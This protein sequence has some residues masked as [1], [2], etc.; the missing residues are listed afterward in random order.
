[1][2]DAKRTFLVAAENGTFPGGKVGGVGDVLRDLPVALAGQGWRPTVL[3]PGYGIFG[4]LPGATPERSVS[5]SFG[6]GTQT[7]AV[8]R[9]PGPDERVQHI[10]FEHPFFSPQGPGRIYCADSDDRPFATDASKF[11]FL[12]AAAAAYIGSL[13]RLPDVVHLHDWHAALYCVLR[14]ND[15]RC[16]ALRSVRTVFTIHNL[17]MQGIRPLDGDASSLRAWLPD[18]DVDRTGVV[19]PRYADCINP[20]AAAIRL[21][22]KLNT[23]SPT[24]AAEILRP[25]APEHGFHGGE[26]LETDLQRA[27]AE[28]RLIGILNGCMYPR[29][30]RRRPG[31]RRL[32]DTIGAEVEGW[33]ERAPADRVFHDAALQRLASLPKRRP[34]TVLTSVGRLTPQKAELFLAGSDKGRNALESILADLGRSGILIMLGSGDRRLQTRMAEIASHYPNFLFLCGYSEAFTDLLYEAGD[35]FLMPSSFEPCGISQMLAMRAGQPCVVHAVGGLRDT[36]WHEVNGF[37][38]EGDTLEAQARNFAATVRRALETKARDPDRWLHIR[39]KAAAAR[40]TWSDAA[41]NYASELY[42]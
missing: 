24:Y 7:V 23:V 39:D 3:T 31:W 2:S 14:A 21:A 26:G 20:M 12:S 15:P 36:V 37:T 10:A 8:L 1:V 29:R 11:A 18:L 33:R 40:F 35:L 41:A 13:D 42:E 6:G 25:D 22:D 4:A 17:A 19:D 27:A 38:F 30:D 28:G 34:A 16:S 9:I 5:V 32:L